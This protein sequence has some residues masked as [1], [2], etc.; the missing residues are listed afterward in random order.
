MKPLTKE[1]LD[2][3]SSN[4]YTDFETLK[5]L[6]ISEVETKE[7]C[8]KDKFVGK[9]Y[10]DSVIALVKKRAGITKPKKKKKNYSKKRGRAKTPAFKVARAFKNLY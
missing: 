3:L 8:W 7:I 5:Y 2:R 9:M 4:G 10:F 6:G 1:L